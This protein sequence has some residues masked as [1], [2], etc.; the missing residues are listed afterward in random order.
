[1]DY[2]AAADPLAYDIAFWMQA[3]DDPAYDAQALGALALELG[4]KLRALGIYGLL[5]TGE[6]IHLRDNL[7]RSGELRLRHLE[8]LDDKALD[9]DHH[10]ALGRPA[11]LLDLIAANRPDLVRRVSGRS[12]QAFDEAREYRDE[13]CYARLLAALSAYA[14]GDAEVDLT[15]TFDA[16]EVWLDGEVDPRLDLCRVLHARDEEAFVDAF[17]ALLANRLE[18]IEAH[19]ETDL[20]DAIIVAE[21]MVFVEGL[22]LLT[23]ARRL[24]LSVGGP[25]AL[26]PPSALASV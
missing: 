25:Y 2:N 3:F 16:Y 17:E 18:T 23:L 8:R 10:A 6:G 15:D 14:D 5:A 13:H 12:A 1:M 4:R 19:R 9:E 11:P 7:V 26:C 20:D 22:A 24:S 21:R